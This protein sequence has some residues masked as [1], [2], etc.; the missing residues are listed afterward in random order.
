MV[1]GMCSYK[2]EV[3]SSK[4]CLDCRGQ[5]L[6]GNWKDAE[7]AGWIT[8]F[9]SVLT[10][11]ELQICTTTVDWQLINQTRVNIMGTMNTCNKTNNILKALGE[12]YFRAKLKIIVLLST[13]K[14]GAS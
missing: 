8:S 9:I 11:L 6:R 12:N 7:V 14:V 13:G 10:F 4:W 5:S 2:K 3:F 1:K